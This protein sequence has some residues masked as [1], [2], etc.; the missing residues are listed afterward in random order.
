MYCTAHVQ[1]FAGVQIK[2]AGRKESGES[3]VVDFQSDGS[4]AAA[5]RRSA[6][7]L[8]ELQAKS[9]GDSPKTEV[10]IWYRQLGGDMVEMTSC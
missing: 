10:Y 5:A 2:R 4:G 3:V 9:K 6:G 7:R 1:Y 8:E